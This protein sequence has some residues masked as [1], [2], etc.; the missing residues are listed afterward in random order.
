MGNMRGSVYNL[1]MNFASK[2]FMRSFFG[3]EPIRAE[4]ASQR[5][6]EAADELQKILESNN[7]DMPRDPEEMAELLAAAR[8]KT[9]RNPPQFER[10]LQGTRMACKIHR[11]N[12]GFSVDAGMPLG[13]QFMSSIRWAFSNTKKAEFEMGLQLVGTP[14]EGQPQDQDSMPFMAINSNSAG[15][16]SMQGQYPLPLGVIFSGQLQMDSDNHQMAQQML[17]LQKNFDDCHLQYSNQ[18]GQV[19]MFSFMHAITPKLTLGY[20]WAHI[21]SLPRAS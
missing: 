6:Q 20:A 11:P 4:C 8:P 12:N 16:L 9:K 17:S 13:Q 2:P 14:A 3:A 21:V 1:T 15:T 5:E 19:H 18:G 10:I 7:G